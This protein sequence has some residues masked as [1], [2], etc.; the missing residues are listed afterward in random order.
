MNQTLK[1]KIGFQVIQGKPQ[2]VQVTIPNDWKLEP[3]EKHYELIKGKIPKTLFE[4]NGIGKLPYL[5]SGYLKGDDEEYA[6]KSDG[7]L[8]NESDVIMI[9]DGDGSGRVYTAN[10]GILASTFVLL[11]KKDSS[12]IDTRFV[13][14]YLQLLFQ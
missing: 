6:E 2:Y 5:T 7:V 1:P 14:Y 13:L 9:G 11:K 4:T 8:V 3:F 12:K 10:N